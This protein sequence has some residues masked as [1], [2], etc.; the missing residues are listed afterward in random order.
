MFLDDGLGGHAEITGSRVIAE[1][2]PGVENFAFR[3]GG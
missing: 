1:A 2:L 3:R